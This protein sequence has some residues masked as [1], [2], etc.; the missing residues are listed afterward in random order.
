MDSF[1]SVFNLEGRVLMKETKVLSGLK[2]EG[3]ICVV[4]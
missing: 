1:V 4:W 3:C 2:L